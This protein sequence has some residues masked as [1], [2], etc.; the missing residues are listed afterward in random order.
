MSHVFVWR[1]EDV[2]GLV[3]LCLFAAILIPVWVADKIS[4]WRK[5]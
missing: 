5:K 1:L 2:F 3:L 4:K